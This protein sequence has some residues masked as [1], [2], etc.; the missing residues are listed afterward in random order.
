MKLPRR[1]NRWQ[2][3]VQ[4]PSAKGPRVKRF[5]PTRTDRVGDCFGFASPVL[6]RSYEA[7]P[8]PR[9]RDNSD[10]SR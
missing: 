3:R 7:T 9:K 8:E 6:Y 4:P 5:R 2:G 1:R 10:G